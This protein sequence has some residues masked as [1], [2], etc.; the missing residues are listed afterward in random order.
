M[1]SDSSSVGRRYSFGP[2]TLDPVRRLLWGDGALVA[3]TP[4]TVDVLTVLVERHGTSVEKDE[5]L[6][7]VWP[8]AVVEENNLPR[9]ISILRKALQ[10]QRGQH[11][12]IC[13][14]PRRA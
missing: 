1:T 10:Q 8:N 9:H 3:L 13:T 7:F 4:K 2:Y 6:R 11:D 14:I 5:L 12:F